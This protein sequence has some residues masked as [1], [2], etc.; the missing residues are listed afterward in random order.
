MK[1]SIQLIID[2][3]Q[4]LVKLKA[5]QPGGVKAISAAVQRISVRNHHWSGPCV[6]QSGLPCTIM[7][8]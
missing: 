1:E 8:G 2:I 5:L 3:F 7:N 6:C 4:I